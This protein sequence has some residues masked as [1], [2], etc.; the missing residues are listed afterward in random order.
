MQFW[1]EREFNYDLRERERLD[2]EESIPVK[3][4]KSLE[5]S[6]FSGVL[7]VGLGVIF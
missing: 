6:L 5:H 1:G 2:A 3:E 7:A 4:L